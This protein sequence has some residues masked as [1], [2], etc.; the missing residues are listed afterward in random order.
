MF[1]AHLVAGTTFTQI[2]LFNYGY[3]MKNNVYSHS[4]LSR[5]FRPEDFYNDARLRDDEAYKNEIIESAIALS[6]KGVSDILLSRSDLKSKPCY[7][8]PL[9]CEKILFRTCA[10]YLKK[11]F[12]M[13]QKNRNKIVDELE[14][15]LKEG[16]A[17]RIYRLDIKSFYESC[18]R[19]FLSRII[20][21]N[22]N[23]SFQTKYIVDSYLELCKRN[24]ICGVPRGV[25]IS[26]ILA[27]ISMKEIDSAINKNKDVIYYAR[28]VDDMI[29]ITTSFEC[30]SA[31]V[32][33]I[34]KEMLS[35]GYTL[36]Q[37]KQKIL[38]LD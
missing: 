20:E 13:R 38:L 26:S 16:S 19:D 25:E 22:S 27:E 29:I 23:I 21:Q 36:N 33:N 14:E 7:S 35:R 18:N 9:L 8:A 31:F 2:P 32:S 3:P 15:Y 34:E 24:N 12:G 30:Q 11:G 17:Y 5:R 10:E 6:C 28:Y 1:S 4:S 37:K